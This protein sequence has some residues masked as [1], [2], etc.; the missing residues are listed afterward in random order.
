[1]LRLLESVPRDIWHQIYVDNWF[2]S[3]PLQV[4]LWKQGVACIGTV[5]PNRL[6]GCVLPSDTQLAKGGRGSV[7]MKSGIFEGVKLNVVK[8]SDNKSVTLLST[9]A[10]IDPVKEVQRWDRKLMQ[11]INNCAVQQLHG[12]G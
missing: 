8:W 10:A 6:K 7:I 2:N 4:T 11:N 9:F 3:L 5:R 12:R 1:M